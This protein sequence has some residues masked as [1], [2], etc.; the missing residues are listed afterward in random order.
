MPSVRGSV[1]GSLMATALALAPGAVPAA[2]V[3]FDFVETGGN[4]VGTLS[5]SL[6]LTTLTPGV[7]CSLI[8]GEA[9]FAPQVAF[10]KT[11][12][13]DYFSPGFVMFGADKPFLPDGPDIVFAT[14]WDGPRF[15]LQSF[16]QGYI[17]WLEVERT[18]PGDDEFFFPYQ[19]GTPLAGTML[20]ESMTLAG[21]GVSPGSYV[22]TFQQDPEQSFTLRFTPIPLPGALPLL[23]G[24]LG[25]LAL[26]RRRTRV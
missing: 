26:L 4:V 19:S 25:L 1:A 5:G 3:L 7:C 11:G 14:S 6:D 24:A 8:P 13:G 22:Y 2:S 15:A 12:S 17:F 16:T 23:L 10:I 9:R 20:F 18:G 21:L